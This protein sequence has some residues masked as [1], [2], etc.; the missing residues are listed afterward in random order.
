MAGSE[1]GVDRIGL[2]FVSDDEPDVEDLA[3]YLRHRLGGSAP[4]V[5]VR[6]PSIPRNE[7]G[8]VLRRDLAA[9]Y[10]SLGM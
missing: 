10:E 8:K 1:D 4:L 5:Y 2:A 7:M 6:L 9:T 3:Q